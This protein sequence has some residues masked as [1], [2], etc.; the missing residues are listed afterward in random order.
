[1]NGGDIFT[2]LAARALGQTPLVIP[3]I[4]PR[5]ALV[6]TLPVEPRRE[7]A[8]RDDNGRSG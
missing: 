5:F 1:M 8:E 7:E 3:R 4:P 2:R 6:P